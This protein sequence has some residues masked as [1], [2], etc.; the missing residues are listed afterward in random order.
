[1]ENGQKI[2]QHWRGK[3]L[4]NR[5]SYTLYRYAYTERQAWLIMCRQIARKQGVIPSMVMNYFNGDQDNYKIT[6]ETE[7]KETD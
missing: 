3:F 6:I 4:F 5:Q 1:M 7:Y 2:K